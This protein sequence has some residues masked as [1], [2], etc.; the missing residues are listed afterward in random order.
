MKRALVRGLLLLTLLV[1]WGL[2]LWRLDYQELRGDEVFG[3]FFS[4]RPVADMVQA[5]VDL[6][7]PHPI[8][9]YVVQ[10][11][12]LAWAGH[13]EFAL[14]FTSAW[15]GLLAVALLWRLARALDLARSAALLA[16]LLLAISPYAIWH[17]QDARMYSMS[18]A[19][20]T[21]S[22]WL[23]IAWLQRQRRA[24]AIAY[25]IISWLA[26]HTYYFTV[27]VLVAQNL[28]ILVRALQQSRLRFTLVNW[29]ILQATIAFFYGPWLL[30]VQET[31]TGYH[32]NGDS[33][34]VIEMLRRA[35]NVFLVGESVPASQRLWW[36]LL[37]GLLLA[38][39]MVTLARS[40]VNGPRAL[41]LLLLYLGVPL[42]ATWWSATQ[43][44]IFNERYLVAAAPPF[45][46]LLAAVFAHGLFA[47]RLK[48]APD[49]QSAFK[50]TEGA[51]WGRNSFVGSKQV[52][53]S[54]V[55]V[56][57]LL[58]AVGGMLLSLGRHYTDP[59]YSKTRG[60]RTLAAALTQWSQGFP[61]AAVRIAQ[62]FPDPTLWYYYSGDV[63]HVVLPPGPQDAAGARTTVQQL[64]ADGV[65]RILLPRQPAP[66]W[67]DQDLAAAALA[68]TYPLI[69]EAVVGVWPVRIYG[70]PPAPLTP[71]DAQFTN[72]VTLTGFATQPAT[73][74]P[75]NVLA[76]YLGWQGDHAT[77][78]GSEKVFVQ[79][80]DASGQLV[81]QD[82]RPFALSSEPSAM[83]TPAIYGILLPATLPPGD[84]RLIAGL[85]DP[86][87]PGAP[88]V[89][90][91]AGVDHIA[92][93][94]LTVE[95][96]DKE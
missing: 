41:T 22:T 28:F 1:G 47:R 37:A 60:W 93:K 16:T 80:L 11:Q 89:L 46:L 4:L 92:I 72:E 75:G 10:Q 24:W 2:R 21:A 85:Y 95:V 23:M 9:S 86:A 15:F 48:P 79:L 34:T 67:D 90:T 52:L 68:T 33:P 40:G 54:F 57:L 14:R 49:R 12:W 77:L 20:T 38:W 74:T 43:R 70:E 91:R 50:R 96:Q 32:G 18:L 78:T 26:L 56:A 83:T 5:T 82:D 13:S 19:L 88:R 3:Y 17:S 76:V 58:M 39:G 30:R 64:H 7:E 29:L 87:Q 55:P 6:Q 31:L 81:A 66:H 27:F 84:Y 53:H 73:L 42:L 25:V 61:P 69:Y 62:N 44:P 94:T 51:T 65:Q 45:Y 8:A 35:G 63:A 59:A 36:A 71:V